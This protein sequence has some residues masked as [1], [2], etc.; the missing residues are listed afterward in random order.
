MSVHRESAVVLLIALL[1][2]GCT[3]DGP[4]SAPVPPTATLVAVVPTDTPIPATAT[5]E[6]PTGTPLPPTITLAPP[7]ATATPKPT[8]TLAPEST[9][10]GVKVTFVNIAGFLITVGD[11][12]ILIDALYHGY[13]EGILKPVISAQPPFDGVDLILVTHEHQDHLSPELVLSHMSSN[14]D[15][16]LVSSQS[17]VDQVVARDA[18][19]RDRVIPIQLKALYRHRR[20][21]QAL[22]HR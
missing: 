20:G 13:P 9:F 4:T 6:P 15:A 8:A 12:K 2:I 17:A 11:K 14:P 5:S 16:I 18:A 21:G 10:D 22:P 7:T 19:I 1:V 3:A